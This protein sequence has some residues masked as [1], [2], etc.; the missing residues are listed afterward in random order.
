[1]ADEG[2]VV[3]LVPDAVDGI[4]ARLGEASVRLEDA[5]AWATE[6]TA[7]MGCTPAA[8]RLAASADWAEDT[9]GRWP[10]AGGPHG[11]RR[12]RAPHPR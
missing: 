6:L 12:H 1:M 8:V 3:L 5:A 9:A 11:R 2:A 4:A 7:P 10:L